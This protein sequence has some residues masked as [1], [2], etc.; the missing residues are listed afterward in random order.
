[1]KNFKRENLLFS[2]CGLNCG[3]C[4]MHLDHYCPGCGGGEGNQSCPIAKCSLEHG[5]V[6]CCVS[7]TEFPCP[8]YNF[9]EEYEV[10]ITSRNRKKDL[11]KYREIGE[12]A[13]C[14][15]QIEKAKLLNFLLENCNDGRRKSFFC[16]A[17][18]LLELEEVRSA[19]EEIS[20]KMQEEALALKEIAAFSAQIFQK[21]A[22]PHGIVLKLNRKP[23]G[24]K[25]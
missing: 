11:E 5:G 14:S 2:L 3:L 6:Q 10:I 7:C 16:L 8:K 23:R 20:C 19:V 18:N 13:Y 15:E 17:V 9:A 22:D 24:K 21:R 4:T 25:A 12:A 1:M